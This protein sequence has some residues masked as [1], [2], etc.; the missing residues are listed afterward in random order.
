MNTALTG[1][2]GRTGNRTP[3]GAGF[4]ERRAFDIR[5]RSLFP[6]ATHYSLPSRCTSFRAAILSGLPKLSLTRCIVLS[7]RRSRSKVLHRSRF[8]VLSAVR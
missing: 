7:E 6:A 4:R 3:N 5:V 1:F 8:T 2:R